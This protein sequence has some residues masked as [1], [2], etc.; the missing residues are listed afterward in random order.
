[1]SS[2]L[3]P[4][5]LLLLLSLEAQ[6]APLGLSVPD[7][8]LV[9]DTT[10]KPWSILRLSDDNDFLKLGPNTDQFYTNGVKVEYLRQR[11]SDPTF[12]DRWAAG[13]ADIK[14]FSSSC[15]LTFGMSIYTPRDIEQ[16]PIDTLDR[17]YSGWMWLAGRHVASN[18]A[19]GRLLALEASLGL[20]GPSAQQAWV[21]TEF[22]EIIDSPKPLGWNTQIADDPAL[23]LNARWEERI[24][25]TCGAHL[26]SL[27]EMNVGTVANYAGLGLSIRLGRMQDPFGH[28]GGFGPPVHNVDLYYF[29]QLPSAEPTC[30]LEDMQVPSA[31][32]CL[33]MD[34]QERNCPGQAYFFVNPAVRYMARNS[35]LQGGVFNGDSSPHTFSGSEI[36]HLYAQ[37]EVGVVLTTGWFGLTFSQFL[38]TREFSTGDPSH[39]GSVSVLVLF[40]GRCC[41]Q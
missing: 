23:N 21:Q 13:N 38:R 27:V 2:Y 16:V 29:G 7:M 36:E 17:P 32:P 3:G 41:D 11:K 18:P 1:M 9:A 40:N 12:L 31:A 28:G 5:S 22:H 30:S 10:K 34:E 19:Q 25:T 37:L 33:A 4:V 20:L 15:G 24:G 26:G 35:L 8:G 14:K 6:S 39:W